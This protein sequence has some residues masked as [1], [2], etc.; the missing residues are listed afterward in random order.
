MK[1]ALTRR[2]SV[3]AAAICAVLGAD[4]AL[5]AQTPPEDE[6][7][8]IVTGTRITQGGIQDIKQ[9][10]SISM[11]TDFLPRAESLTI[12]G[13]LG[14]YDLSL[15]GKAECTQTFCISGYSAKSDIPARPQDEYFVGLGFESNADAEALQAEPLSLIAVVDRSGSMTGAKIANAKEG[16]LQSLSKMRDGDRLGI[17]MFG[18]D[19]AILMPVMDVGANRE[20]L[21]DAIKSIEAGGSTNM[22]RGLQQGFDV[23]FA[24]KERTNRKTRIMLL[25]DEK[26][27][28]G[29]TEP[30]GFMTQAIAGS[31][32]GVGMTTI[33]VGRDFDNALA[34]QLSSV[35]GGNLFYLANNADA[36]ALFDREFFNMVSEVAHDVTITMTPSAGNKINAVFGVPNEI[37]TADADGS[38]TVKIGSAFL[39]TNGGGI[40]ASVDAAEGQ[41]ASPLMSV[42]VSYV[43]AQTGA[44]GSNSDV[45]GLPASAP[46]QGL[47]VAQT[48]VDEY[49]TL[50]EALNA[51]H[52]N[53]DTQKA[54]SLIDGLAGRLAQTEFAG[55]A[56]ER[57]LVSGLQR[58]AAALAGVGDLPDNMRPAAVLGKWEVTK[59][60]GL[61]EIERGDLVEIT[62]GGEFNT[63]R[64]TGREAGQEVNQYFQINENQLYI[65][66]TDLVFNYSVSSDTLKL[67][68][69]DG[70]T[71]L[72]LKRAES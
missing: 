46:P 59:Q 49:L 39:S 36:S 31:K 67:R 6:N 19:T 26:P 45:V 55:I 56:K 38:V 2:I 37:V 54:Y 8:V 15:P 13:L 51:Y 34:M 47:K 24:E 44:A 7:V 64:R 30:E 25:T 29:S 50:T 58:N 18:D 33:G 63:Y 21:I 40:F 10:R 69:K 35:R 27:N 61:R 5:M 53:N 14:E 22:E 3:S 71:R 57:E 70:R 65:E 23:A 41:G 11:D 32:R 9:F 16:L 20:Q 60:R 28:V 66:Y 1:L 62:Q 4:F 42:A 12:E 52:A 17:V 48:L 43:D 68:G 72:F